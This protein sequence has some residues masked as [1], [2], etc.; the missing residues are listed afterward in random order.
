MNIDNRTITYEGYKVTVTVADAEM[1][2]YRTLLIEQAQAE[3]DEAEKTA[4]RSETNLKGFAKRLLHTI[5]YPS[6][7]AAVVDHEGFEIWPVPFTVFAK[8][9]E[10]L[11]IEWETAV[12]DLNKHW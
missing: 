5:L 8:L 4:P 10:P 12:F 2:M 6:L 7:I 9:P 1:G 11:V 3:E